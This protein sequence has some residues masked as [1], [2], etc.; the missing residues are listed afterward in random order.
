MDATFAFSGRTCDAKTEPNG[1]F[2]GG[3]RCVSPSQAQWWGTFAEAARGGALAEGFSLPSS[4]PF[5][6]LEN[7]TTHYK[8]KK[9]TIKSGYFSI[10]LN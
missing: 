8:K 7:H 5:L 4:F 1:D 6:L 2:R 9:K 10:N 3:V